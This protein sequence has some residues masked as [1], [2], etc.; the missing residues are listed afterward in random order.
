MAKDAEG[1]GGATG[2]VKVSPLRAKMIQ[3][4]ELAGLCQKTQATY[5]S[6]VKALQ[7][8]YGTRPDRLTEEEV[9]RYV[10]W[11]R[12]DGGVAKGTFQTRFYGLKFFYYRCL[13]CD[14]SLFTKKKVR[15]PKAKRLPHALS[16]EQ[17]LRLVEAFDK[18]VYRLCCASMVTLGLRLRDAISL[19]ITAIHSEQ[20]VL[21]IVSKGNKERIVPFPEVLLLEWRVFWKTHRHERWLFP[22]MKGTD[23]LCRKSMYRA[24]GRA[25]ERAGLGPEFTLHSLRHSFAT[26]LL[27]KGVDVRIVQMLLGHANLRSTQVYTHMTTVIEKGVRKHVAAIAAGVLPGGQT[28]GQ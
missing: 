6:A 21:R 24:F 3:D 7:A 28:H 10:A 18:P 23:H 5:I 4:M 20:M 22:N 9:Y 12:G 2:G 14:W 15:L 27:E 17:C 19:P 26:Q 13:G 8:H 1:F 11:L 16:S 25:R